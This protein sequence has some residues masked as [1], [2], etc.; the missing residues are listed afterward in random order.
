M[1]PPRGLL[2]LKD[3]RR[4]WIGN[5]IENAEHAEKR[6]KKSTVLVLF[7]YIPRLFS[8]VPR[9]FGT[10]FYAFDVAAHGLVIAAHVLDVATHTLDV[11]ARVLFVASP[12][13]IIA[14][15]ALVVATC[16]MIVAGGILFVASCI[17]FV[18]SHIIGVNFG[19][20][21][22]SGSIRRNG[23]ALGVWHSVLLLYG[24]RKFVSGSLATRRR[25]QGGGRAHVPGLCAGGCQIFAGEFHHRHHGGG[26]GQ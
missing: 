23:E 26:G 18:A 5:R 13:L 11:A 16:A 4:E 8:R 21:S 19:V 14:T 10:S 6:R 22:G 9:H 7:S 24:F 17:L 1:R 12:A 3:G 25:T 15:R 20:T 2:F